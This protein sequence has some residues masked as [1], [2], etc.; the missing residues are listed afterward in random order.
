MLHVLGSQLLFSRFLERDVKVLEGMRF[1]PRL[2]LPEGEPMLH[3]LRFLHDLPP[4]L[5][6]WVPAA[7]TVDGTGRPEPAAVRA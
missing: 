6:S 5:D 2:P 7:D 3:Y 1:R 4:A